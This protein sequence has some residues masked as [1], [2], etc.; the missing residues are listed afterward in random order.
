M[1]MKKI[2]YKASG[3][4]IKKAERLTQ[5][6]KR[7][8]PG[9]SQFL[10]SDYAGLWPFLAGRY[11]RPVLA[12]S[13]DGVGTKVL[14]ASYFNEWA[15]IG[16]D[17]V[18]MCVNDLIC[19]GAK[20]L[21]FMDYY[22]CGKLSPSL[23]RSFFRGLQR[24]CRMAGAP[25]LGGETAELAGLYQPK[26]ADCAGF[27]VGVVEKSKILNPAK[28]RP[29]DDIVALKSSGFHSNGYS[30]LRAIY[31]SPGLLKKNKKILMRPT[32]LYTFL[33]PYLDQIKGLRAMAHITGG[34]LGNLSRILPSGLRAELKPWPVPSCFLDA[35]KR[36]G[37]PWRDFLEIFN[38][39]L[40]LVL[41]IK[42]KSALSSLRPSRDIIYLGKVERAVKQ[43]P[44]WKLDCK[45][46]EKA[47]AF[48][49]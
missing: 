9:R 15:G 35:K 11:K 23:A 48:G 3:V 46:M 6:I 24:A 12:A 33:I 34:G 31:S 29:G 43:A 32:R 17:L 39:G 16:Q 22:A 25:L 20:P 10:S 1:I 8:A 18:A 37:L 44:A 26:D 27:C 38:C 21:F 7:K 40:G 45:A 5:W 42:N 36:A 28:V 30:L 4:D 14:L 13:A 2:S 41:I 49:Q 19:V 47:N